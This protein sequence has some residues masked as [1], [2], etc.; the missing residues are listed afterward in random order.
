[1]P[2]RLRDILALG[3]TNDGLVVDNFSMVLFYRGSISWS[4][5]YWMWE[6]VGVCPPDFNF[7]G[8]G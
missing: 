8:L 7:F 6:L 5:T 3:G 4:I 1:M 2:Q